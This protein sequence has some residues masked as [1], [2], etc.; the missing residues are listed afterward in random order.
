MIDGHA[1]LIPT[2]LFYL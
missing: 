1:S 2:L